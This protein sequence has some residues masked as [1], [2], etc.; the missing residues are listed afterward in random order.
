MDKRTSAHG[1]PTD[2]EETHQVNIKDSEGT[3]LA[4]SSSIYQLILQLLRY[5]SYAQVRVPK[6]YFFTT[7]LNGGYGALTTRVRL[8]LAIIQD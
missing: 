5:I 1:T 4:L 7:L 6:S 2:R 3:V 8:A